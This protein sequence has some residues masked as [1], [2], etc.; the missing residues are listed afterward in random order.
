MIEELRLVGILE[1]PNG[2]MY[3]AIEAGNLSYLVAPG[4]ELCNGV[5]DSIFSEGVV[6]HQQVTGP[7]HLQPYQEVVLT[8]SD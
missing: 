7:T 6:F 5:L 4:T 3:A 2:N 1:L 8:I